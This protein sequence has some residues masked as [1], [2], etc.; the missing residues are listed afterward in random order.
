[1]YIEPMNIIWDE[2]K[3]TSNL[4]K[5]R[6]V[7]FEEAA[8]CLLDPMALVVEDPDAESEQRFIL[9]GMSSEGRLLNVCYALPDANTIRIISARKPTKREGS[10][11]A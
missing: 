11:Y 8:T 7:S 2:N 10:S 6:G 1:M 5:H 9:I 4:R 3:A